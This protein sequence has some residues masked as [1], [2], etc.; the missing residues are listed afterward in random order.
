MENKI[1]SLI[2]RM[3]V[4]QEKVENQ[5]SPIKVAEIVKMGYTHT[6]LL[7]AVL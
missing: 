5:V 6:H 2:L 3:L 4:A 1:R 7:T